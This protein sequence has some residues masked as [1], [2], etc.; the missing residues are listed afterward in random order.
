MA[1]DERA[2]LRAQ[3]DAAAQRRLEAKLLSEAAALRSTP[4]AEAAALPANSRG[5]LLGAYPAQLAGAAS[6]DC[7][8]AR[9]GL[10]DDAITDLVLRLLVEEMSAEQDG[11]QQRD[12]LAQLAGIPQQPE[13]L[14]SEMLS[15][16][17]LEGCS[18]GPP[19]SGGASEAARVPSADGRAGGVTV[20]PMASRASQGRT[21]QP[22]SPSQQQGPVP[23]REV[24]E[25][26]AGEQQQALQR[27]VRQQAELLQQQQQQQSKLEV[28]RQQAAAQQQ[29]VLQ[30]LSRS[31]GV[32]EAETEARR[33]AEAE[34]TAQARQAERRA[35][36]EKTA[37]LE[38]GRVAQ[39]AAVEAAEAA[40]A[41]VSAATSA[42]AE[43][44]AAVER[45]AEEAA[46][47][48]Q[49]RAALEVAAAAQVA[50][51][52]EA[53]RA[54]RQ[55]QSAVETKLAAEEARRDEE[56]TAH[57]EREQRVESALGEL[58]QTMERLQREQERAQEQAQRRAQEQS[59]KGPL[60]R[61]EA[62]A[63]GK[64]IASAVAKR[65]IDDDPLGREYARLAEGRATEGRSRRRKPLAQGDTAGSGIANGAVGA[66]GELAP[67][68]LSEG[69]IRCA[70][71]AA[72]QALPPYTPHALLTQ[73]LSALTR[74]ASHQPPSPPQ[75]RRPHHAI[76]TAL[77][78]PSAPSHPNPRGASPPHRC[79][80]SEG[81]L[82][83]FSTS[84]APPRTP[85][86]LGRRLPFGP[87]PFVTSLPQLV[88]G[89]PLGGLGVPD[90]AL[91]EIS[92]DLSEG[93]LAL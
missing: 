61:R 1:A 91:S 23:Q 40:K 30:L 46:E 57:G 29:L 14:T 17:R 70:W 58:S 32:L 80:E 36:D 25:E 13:V 83:F 48:R 38:F 50:A 92:G 12:E 4:S 33:L 43:T 79:S 28:E 90:V 51:A 66:V 45:A 82:V 62:K 37:A 10:G 77:P 5:V 85:P 18:A 21:P 60:A 6:A 26:R 2:L 15:N 65:L 9:G 67:T 27:Q 35:E 56:R 75:P 71:R 88:S 34:R 42:M 47:A 84:A 52:E 73:S 59:A 81:E 69:E 19:G 55:M 72:A 76:P 24:P 8:L 44:R 74:T 20:G 22:A 68:E 53:G 87:P 16:E 78:P 7:E 93:E 89:L 49:A 64:Q 3:A 39:E 41:V 86:D 11:Q 54:A 31:Q 63:L